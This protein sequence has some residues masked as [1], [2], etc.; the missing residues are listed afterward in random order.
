[1]RPKL[2][3]LGGHGEF[4]RYREW[5]R[6]LYCDPSR[7]ICDVLGR[8]VLFDQEPLL[9]D[10]A[11]VC[12]GGTAGR[13]YNP[14]FWS[15]ERAHRIAWIGQ[16]LAAP[17]KIHPDKDYASRHKYL[18]FLPPDEGTPQD[19]EFYCVIVRV[20]NRRTVAFLTAYN[21]TSRTFDEYGNVGPRVYPPPKPKKRR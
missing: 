11:H 18:L 14:E 1:M 17:N 10:C 2:R 20:L 3:D 4:H 21:V 7:P 15:P 12:Y 9:D 5:F 6:A 8:R 16:A 19:N 13:P